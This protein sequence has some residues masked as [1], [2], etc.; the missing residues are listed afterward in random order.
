M[1]AIAGRW[2]PLPGAWTFP[3]A[4]GVG[5]RCVFVLCAHTRHSAP[6]KLRS[7]G[8]S[9]DPPPEPTR[10]RSP[11]VT[12]PRKT[13]RWLSPH[14]CPGPLRS[15]FLGSGD[16]CRRSCYGNS[17]G[18]WIWTWTTHLPR[19]RGLWARPQPDSEGLP[20]GPGNASATGSQGIQTLCSGSV[21]TA[22]L[23]ICR[24]QQ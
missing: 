19:P 24:G 10:A 15:N 20:T 7:E 14:L 3:K 8:C 23:C 1:R 16:S 17:P 11:Q 18:Q 6:C 21:P 22:G 13:R 2:L 5:S 4:T 9:P 12:V